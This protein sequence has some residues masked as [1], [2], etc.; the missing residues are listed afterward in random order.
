MIFWTVANLIL[1]NQQFEENMQRQTIQISNT[2]KQP[3]KKHASISPMSGHTYLEAAP[4]ALA[5]KTPEWKFWLVGTETMSVEK[6][7]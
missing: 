5:T 3:H 7:L 1:N 2:K 6:G 4:G